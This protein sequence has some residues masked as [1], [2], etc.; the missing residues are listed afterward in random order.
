MFDDEPEPAINKPYVEVVV[1]WTSWPEPD[2]IAIGS[3]VWVSEYESLLLVEV[4]D[5]DDYDAD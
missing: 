3:E 4:S 2:Y 1:I 5:V